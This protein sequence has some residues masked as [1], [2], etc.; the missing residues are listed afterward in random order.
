M[1]DYGDVA[2]VGGLCGRW[3]WLGK[4]PVWLL[5]MPNQML[6]FA[7][8]CLGRYPRKLLILTN[9]SAQEQLLG[10]VVILPLFNY[11][12]YMEAMVQSLPVHF[13][14]IIIITTAGITQHC[15]V[16]LSSVQFCSAFRASALIS[17]FSAEHSDQC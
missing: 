2:S 5:T 13:L 14:F 15:S 8:A 17:S 7:D 9:A 16:S 4:K 10:L 12:I 6:V 3:W 11:I 1:G